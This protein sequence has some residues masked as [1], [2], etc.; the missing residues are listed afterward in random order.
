MNLA[1]LESELMLLGI[2]RNI[3]DLESNLSIPEMEAILGATR[4]R[5]YRQQKFAAALKGIDLDEQQD[6][7]VRE[8]MERVEARAGAR[9]RGEDPDR[10]EYKQMGI[11]F[12]T[13]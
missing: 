8:R 11:V 5:E 4:E 2:W 12:E 6:E 3:Q 1:E 7:D 10:A 9:L 13:D